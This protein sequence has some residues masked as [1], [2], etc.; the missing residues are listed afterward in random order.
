MPWTPKQAGYMASNHPQIFKREV[1]KLGAALIK[2]PVIRTGF[3]GKKK[4]SK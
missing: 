1:A 2:K 4:G 3:G